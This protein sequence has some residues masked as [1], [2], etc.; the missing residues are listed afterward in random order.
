MHSLPHHQVVT[1]MNEEA[2]GINARFSLMME[3]FTKYRSDVTSYKEYL[4]KAM[5][6]RVDKRTE[7]NLQNEGNKEQ[8][9]IVTSLA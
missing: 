4:E 5:K 3:Q 2:S 6:D 9:Q 7:G 1:K 8:K